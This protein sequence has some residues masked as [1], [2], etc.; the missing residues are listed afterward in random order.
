F[1]VHLDSLDP[2]HYRAASRRDGLDRVLA[3]LR[4]LEDRGAVPIK[5]NVVLIRGV[6]DQEIPEFA[7][8]ARTRPW[9]VRFIE[10][11]PLGEGDRLEA[12]SEEHT[13]ELQSRSDLVCRLLLE[14]KK[15][16]KENKMSLRTIKQI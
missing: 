7:E 6:N 15:N 9:Q 12:R 4:E 10:M 8:L 2:E 5:V 13:S 1:N 16:K 11:M 14:K 3:G